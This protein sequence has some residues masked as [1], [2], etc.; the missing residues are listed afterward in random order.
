MQLIIEDTF[1]ARPAAIK[2]QAAKQELDT[3]KEVVINMLQN[4]ISEPQVGHL[5]SV[6]QEFLFIGSL[7][8]T[9]T[10]FC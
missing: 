4:L 8:Y 6:L 5:N 2:G 7:K 10:K 9:L 3:Q 1:Q